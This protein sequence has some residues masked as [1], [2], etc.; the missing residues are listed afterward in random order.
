VI[1]VSAAAI[2]RQP[3]IIGFLR[4]QGHPQKGGDLNLSSCAQSQDDTSAG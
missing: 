1:R 3:A 4:L 2:A